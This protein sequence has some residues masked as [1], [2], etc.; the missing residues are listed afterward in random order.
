MYHVDITLPPITT[1]NLASYRRKLE[2]MAAI[3]LRRVRRAV[4]V[5]AA[6][7]GVAGVTATLLPDQGGMA[8]FQAMLILGML[9]FLIPTLVAVQAVTSR[10]VG[11]NPSAGP[12]LAMALAWL[13]GAGAWVHALAPNPDAMAALAIVALAVMQASWVIGG[14][15][16]K[17]L[18]GPNLEL[19]RLR[20]IESTRLHD[21]A[22]LTEGVPGAYLN[23][24]T[25]QGRMPV[26]ME[27]DALLEH[28][29]RLVGSSARSTSGR[30]P[31][32][33]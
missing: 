1:E 9:G 22:R 14:G 17:R 4:V 3:R 25:R 16:G 6:V 27:Y 28:A 30:H 29:H 8:M 13:A 11:R 15:A 12:L 32:M 2:A 19:A 33:A 23:A 31:Q 18:L 5:A 26:A 24:V 7:A 21:L 10:T 20:P